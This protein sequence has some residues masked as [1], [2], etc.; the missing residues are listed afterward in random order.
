M[1]YPV[2]IFS[3]DD[4]RGGITKQILQ[5]NNIEALRV[6]RILEAR[7]TI[8]KHAPA[9]T[10]FDTK[11]GL[12]DE[13]TFLSNFCRTLKDC[14]VIILGSASLMEK[15]EG[16]GLDRNVCLPD[17]FDP[18]LIVSTV[19]KLLQSKPKTNG[20]AHKALEDDL[21]QFLKLE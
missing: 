8:A 6:S 10:I 17:P 2:I 15:F 3:A 1:S 11:N 13:I 14:A 16:S 21:K 12:P 20:L 19:R 9:V 7:D 4:I 18:E 5:Q